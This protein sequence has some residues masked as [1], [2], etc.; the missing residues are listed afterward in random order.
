MLD[1][2]RVP[3]QVSV[4]G[5]KRFTGHNEEMVK[6]LDIHRFGPRA[7][8]FVATALQRHFNTVEIPFQ[9]KSYS[10]GKGTGLLEKSAADFLD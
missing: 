4:E 6:K 3:L 8:S 10:H 1:S 9:P 5:V 2:V 7:Y